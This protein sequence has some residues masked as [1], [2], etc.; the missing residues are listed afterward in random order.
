[1][2]SLQKSSSCCSRSLVGVLIY[3]LTR[4]RYSSWSI[5]VRAY[6]TISTFLGRNWLR[7]SD[8][9]SSSS[10]NCDCLACAL[11][12]LRYSQ[13]R[14]AQETI[15][16]QKSASAAVA[17]RRGRDKTVADDT[18]R[19]L[20]GKITGGTEDHD[21]RVVLELH[22]TTGGIVSITR[23][24]LAIPPGAS[25]QHPEMRSSQRGR[26]RGRGR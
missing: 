26:G 25:S 22:G 10:H 12:K 6:P 15:Q 21:N 8:K 7:Y 1:M 23:L 19:L 13:G 4:F 11:R 24:S 9:V 17:R 5:F 16:I 3:D 14:R 20:L 18:N 2:H